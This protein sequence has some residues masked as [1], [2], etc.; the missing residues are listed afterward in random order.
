MLV[1][2][3]LASQSALWTLN[4]AL[5]WLMLELTDSPFWVGLLGF[6]VGLP[7]LAVSIPAGL[8]LDRWNRRRAVVLC[9]GAML[10]VGATLTVLV[11]ASAARPWELL[12]AAFVNGVFAATNNIARQTITPGTV[13]RDELGAAV[14]VASAASNGARILGP[15]LAGFVIGYTGNAGAFVL[16][17]LLA[18]AGTVFAL[19]LSDAVTGPMRAAPR[20]SALRD[21]LGYLAARPVLRDLTVLAAIP[22]F[23]AFPYL[24]FLPVFARD[25]LALGPD[26]LGL[27]MGLSGAGAV[28]GGLLCALAARF[29]WRGR[30][31]L[32][33][34]LAYGGVLTGF[35]LATT[36][37]PA[38]VLLAITAMTGSLF[39]S[40][41]N[42]LLQMELDDEVRGR[43]TGIYLLTT[44]LYPL[45]AL[46]M[47]WLADQFGTQD[48]VAGCALAASL[49]A[50][51][52]VTRSRQLWR[53]GVG[54]A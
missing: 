46:P 49:L 12:L 2:T 32:V 21:A 20:A 3:T 7:M 38:A 53:L 33:L 50:G 34:Q 52:V 42:T 37:V 17:C 24:Q 45:G 28:V 54:G 43:V 40:L 5:G 18:L 6:A 26:G 8:L 22:M 15:S 25:V 41:N 11:L 36:T 16:Q 39:W 44:S 19:R 51:L 10:A 35:A 13:P 31:L 4:L 27:L 23:V 48:A 9:Q 29:A 14:G 47:G 1:L 30:L